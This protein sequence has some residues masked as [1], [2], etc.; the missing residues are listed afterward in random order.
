MQYIEVE[1]IKNS[2][3]VGS[4]TIEVLAGISFA[5]GQGEFVVVTGTS[6]C[7]K[8]T[9]LHNAGSVHAETKT[10]QKVKIR[11]IYYGTEEVC[12]LLWKE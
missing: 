3:T 8:S 2:Y 9:L 12:R 11:A 1:N 7:G 4:E 5:G 6:G 10:G